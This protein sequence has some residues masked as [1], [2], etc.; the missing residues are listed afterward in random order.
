MNLRSKRNN[1]DFQKLTINEY[2]KEIETVIS[3]NV[4][5]DKLT[6]FFT[7]K[8][9]TETRP[10]LTRRKLKPIDKRF[11]YI[12]IVYSD[13]KKVKA[14]LW[15]YNSSL[16]EL[17]DIFGKANIHNTP[18]DNSTVFYF[19]S[20]NPYIERI[21]TIHSEWLEKN[22]DLE[23]FSTDKSGKTIYKYT[24]LYF[25]DIQISI[26]RLNFMKRLL[27]KFSIKKD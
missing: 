3:N 5:L 9:F 18:Y 7:E 12:E 19:I 21:S 11:K 10:Y 24:E 2:F 17:E 15:K 4:D 27:Y 14:I 16:N 1:I 25:D 26:R 22:N 20:K 13:N 8:P 6:N 23:Y